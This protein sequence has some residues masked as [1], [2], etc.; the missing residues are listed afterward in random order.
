LIG[1]AAME[2]LSL[3]LDPPIATGATAD[4]HAWR[5]GQVLKL[6]R[7]TI[8][9]SVGP[10]EARITRALHDAGARVPR[11]GDLIEVNGR[12]GLPMEKLSGEPLSLQLV[13]AESGT[14]AGFIA[15]EVHVEM[16]AL[17]AESLTA[18]PV[19]FRK[20]I[21]AG[22]LSPERKERVLRAMESLPDGDRICHGDF[23]AGNLMMT[24][25]GPVVIDCVVAHRGN[26]LADVAQTCVAMTEWLYFR[27]SERSREAVARFI[28]SYER[29]YFELS[30]G[31]R[32]EMAMWKP[33]VAAVRFS[34]PHPPSSEAPLLNMVDGHR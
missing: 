11:V 2:T 21:E 14:R 27:M 9:R 23:H 29:R 32:D 15:A 8:P 20:M 19:Q 4:I 31:G 34:A 16:H 22:T 18:L 10:R 7:T 17:T 5:D 33:I 12:F 28:E 25:D 26:P 1:A 6:Y 30:P 3:E 24:D 13:D